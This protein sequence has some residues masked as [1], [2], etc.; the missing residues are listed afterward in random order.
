L[1]ERLAGSFEAAR[2]EVRAP[3]MAAYLRDQFPFLGL[4]APT[5]RTLARTALAGLPS[6]TEP[7]LAEIARGCW[8]RDEREYQQFAC[9]HLT[10][11]LDVPGPGFLTVVAELIT[12]KSWWD[13]VDPLAAH[14]VGGLVRRHPG[15]TARMDDWS[16]STDLWLIRAA[17][18]HQLL[19]GAETDARRLFTYCT[20]QAAHQDFFIRKAIGWA[21]RQYARTDPA[22]VRTYLTDQAAHLSPLSIREAAKH[23]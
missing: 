7:E 15:L 12:T 3:A 2:D 21:L 1:L 16:E 5:R 9:D 6:P 19:Y 4:D 23:L 20:R 8:A 13:T 22:A 11:H 10:A 18:L 17:I 14:V